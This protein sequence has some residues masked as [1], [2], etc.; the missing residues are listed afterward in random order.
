MA[1]D[2]SCPSGKKSF[3]TKRDAEK[4]YEVEIEEHGGVVDRCHRCRWWHL[5]S[6]K[7]QPKSRR[8]H[9]GR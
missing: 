4:F 1:R 5:S 8:G 2:L 9:R 7:K 6:K 3:K